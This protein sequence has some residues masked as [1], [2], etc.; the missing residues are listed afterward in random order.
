MSEEI[1]FTITT[2]DLGL[3]IGDKVGFDYGF[4]QYSAK[5]RDIT[6]NGKFIRVRFGPWFI[7]G[8]WIPTYY[9]NSHDMK[10]KDEKK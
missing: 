10:C 2:E 7:F 1:M 9:V 5:I 3:K 8:K 4:E 6:P